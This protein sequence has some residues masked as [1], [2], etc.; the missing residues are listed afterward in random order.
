MIHSFSGD[1]FLAARAARARLAELRDEVPEFTELDGELTPEAV[2]AVVG[3]A[4][5]FGASGLY[6]DFDSAFS[7]Q[8]GVK[9][10]NA[11][12]RSLAQLPPGSVLV[13]V[14]SSATEARQKQWRALGEH[15]HLPAPRFGALTRWVAQELSAQGVRYS[16]EVPALITEL[17]GEDLPAIASEA[18]KLSLLERELSGD[19]VRELTGKTEV[20][21]SFALIDALVAADTGRALRLCR[22]LAQQA[23]ETI[24]VLAAITWQFS[25]VARCVAL[26]ANEPRASE[27][28]V[29][30]A[31][32]VK[33]F[34][35]GKVL[36]I[37]GRL[38]EAR[39][40]PLLSSIAAAE[41]ASK[42]GRDADWALEKLTV[43]LSQQLA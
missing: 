8:A 17:F 19:D 28:R 2:Q 36:R 10:R 24:R 5:L 30:S 11:L 25:L 4:G 42:S 6:L 27:G 20:T 43:E 41:L 1:P 13:V 22:A 16:R 35:A 14:D 31:L 37:A 9:P 32:K 18:V 3:Q 7:G 38:D 15:V 39:L 21:D 29:A 40:L 23:E 33:P 26:L 12:L 34:V